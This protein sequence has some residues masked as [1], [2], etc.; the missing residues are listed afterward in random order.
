MI[1]P[2]ELTA[3]LSSGRLLEDPAAITMDELVD[4]RVSIGEPA[5][6]SMS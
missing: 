4:L 6:S 2:P 3:R 5:R 1:V